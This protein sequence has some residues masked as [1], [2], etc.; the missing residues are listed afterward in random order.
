MDPPL[1]Q[2]WGGGV[3]CQPGNSGAQSY[4]D[5]RENEERS[6]GE[7]QYAQVWKELIA[8]IPLTQNQRGT[9]ETGYT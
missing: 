2:S 1:Q 9:L 7:R 3:F 4:G 6:L 8:Q 5:I